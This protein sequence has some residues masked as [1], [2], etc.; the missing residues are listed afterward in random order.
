MGKMSKQITRGTITK[1]IIPH[2]REDTLLTVPM[3][4]VTIKDK[5]ITNRLPK[6]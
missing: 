4:M 3:S 1:G 5:K 6:K 2:K